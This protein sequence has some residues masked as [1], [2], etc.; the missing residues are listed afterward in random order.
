MPIVNFT[1]V[2]LIS[3]IFLIRKVHT[4]SM[5]TTPKQRPIDPT[6]NAQDIF[7][8]TSGLTG[9]TTSSPKEGGAD[10]T[11]KVPDSSNLPGTLVNEPQDQ[12]EYGIPKEAT[13]NKVYVKNARDGMSQEQG[14]K[15]D[16]VAS[17]TDLPSRLSEN[18]SEPTS[19]DVSNQQYTTNTTSQPS[20][21]ARYGE[22][23]VSGDMP[24]PQSD[25]D[26]LQNA[27]DVG[28]QIQE[29]PE[30][31]EEVDIGRDVDKAEEKIWES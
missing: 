15:S 17:E 20:S 25:D 27:Q 10:P 29:D 31:P 23:S 2:F 19:F 1:E 14:E 5:K 18:Y 16:D 22:E 8:D 6:K 21:P 7:S 26:L 30:H 13:S 4:T 3:I 11:E 9:I 12:P 28:T 24:T